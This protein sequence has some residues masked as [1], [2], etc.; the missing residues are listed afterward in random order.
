MSLEIEDHQTLK[1]NYRAAHRSWMRWPSPDTR[2][3]YLGVG[4]RAVLRNGDSDVAVPAWTLLMVP[5]P[6][7][8]KQATASITANVHSAL[9]T[10][11]VKRLLATDPVSMA[12]QAKQRAA[13]QNGG[14]LPRN[15]YGGGV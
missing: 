15:W 2:Q 12:A 7:A 11:N 13:H 1:P 10:G 9:A 3:A 5:V 8:A 14:I 6:V 4:E